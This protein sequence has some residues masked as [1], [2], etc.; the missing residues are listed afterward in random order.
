VGLGLEVDG[1]RGTDEKYPTKKV[2]DVGVR[3]VPLEP[4]PLEPGF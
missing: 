3:F 4:V 2:R 1:L